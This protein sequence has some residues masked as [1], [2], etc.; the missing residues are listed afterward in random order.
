LTPKLPV[1]VVR[2]VSVHGFLKQL[3]TKEAGRVDRGN[4]NLKTVIGRHKA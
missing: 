2:P 3:Y 4:T 1:P